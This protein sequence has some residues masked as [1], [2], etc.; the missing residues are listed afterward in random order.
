MESTRVLAGK[1]ALVCGAS[2]GIGLASAVCIAK[3]GAAVTLVARNEQAL[4]K[5]AG[6]LDRS[7][8]Q[9]HGWIAADFDQP[10]EVASKIRAYVEKS[11]SINILVNNTGGPPH[12]ALTEATPEQFLKAISNHVVCNQL[13]VQALL[14][15]MKA[16]GYGRVINIISTSVIAP[17]KGLGVS[18]TTRGAVANWGRTLAG[19][20]APFG[21]TVNNILPGY[22]D[23]AR[24]QSLFD[25]KALKAGT[26]ADQ[27]KKSVIESIPMARLADPSEIGAVVAFLAS[28]AASYVSGVNL[29]VDGGRTAVQ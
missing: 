14:P 21:I 5:S 8:G 7:G 20:L 26:S 6:Q 28:P 12:G 25:A 3:L 10:A 16:S 4:R 2:Q 18:N 17:I 11:G 23:T 24:L 27:V 13:L 9:E 19:E 15:G 29:P 22:T 1:K